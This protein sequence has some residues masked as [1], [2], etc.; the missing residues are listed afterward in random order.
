MVPPTGLDLKLQ[1]STSTYDGDTGTL[2]RDL[3]GGVV[4]EPIGFIF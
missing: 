3:G 2:Y 1:A 4:L